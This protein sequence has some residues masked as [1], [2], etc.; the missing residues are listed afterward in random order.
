MLILDRCQKTLDSGQGALLDSH[1]LS[2]SH[3]RAR[4]SSQLGS[5]DTLQRLDFAIIDSRGH[6]ASAY[7][8]E[9]SGSQQNRQTA[10]Q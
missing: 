7:D 2:H 6:L 1:P 8:E 9:N 3:V 10:V 5:H 4:F